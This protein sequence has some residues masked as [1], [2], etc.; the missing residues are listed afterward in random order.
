MLTILIA[1][2]IK[3]AWG[4]RRIVVSWNERFRSLPNLIPP[5]GLFLIVIGS[6]YAGWATPTEAASLGVV[7][8]FALAAFNGRLNLKVLRLAFEGTM[9]STAMI[10][11]IFVGAFFLNFV[12][13]SVCLSREITNLITGLKMSPLETMIA[14]V[15]FYVIWAASWRRWRVPRFAIVADHHPMGYDGV[16]RHHHHHLVEVAMIAPS[17][18]LHRPRRSA[19]GIAERRDH[20]ACRS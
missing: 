18:N 11:L 17:V 1:C 20:R 5:L 9:R 16:V 10:M 14:I 8:T 2:L 3:P 19:R 6:I 13:S 15:I 4:G 12:L 7:A